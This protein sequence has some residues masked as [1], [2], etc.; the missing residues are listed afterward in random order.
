M[1]K[2]V[3]LVILIICTAAAALFG[4]FAY[5]STKG[6]AVLASRLPL[7]SASDPYVVFE[8]PENE[9]PL[10]IS[11][12][13]TEGQYAVFR[14]GSAGNRILSIAKTAKECAVLIEDGDEE[15][16]DIYAVMR[17]LP[18]DIS[19][20]SKGDLPRSWKMILGNT[21]VRKSGENGS[22]EIKTTDADTSLYYS[23]EREIA[24]ISHNRDSFFKMLDVRSGSVKGIPKNYWGKEKKS[25]PA[26]IEISDGGLLFTDDEIQPPL[27]LKAAWRSH[28]PDKKTGRIGEAIWKIQ[29]LDKRISPI[30]LKALE[31]KKWDTTNC[32]IPEP[33]LLSAGMNLPERKGSPSDWPFPLKTI[34]ELGKSMGLSEKKIQKILSG[35]TIFSVGGYNKLL[36]FSLP[37]ILAEFTGDKDLMREL[38]DAFWN[39]LFFGAEPRPIDGFDFGGTT[40]VPF[41]VVGAGR[42]NV[43]ILGLL[44]PESIKETVKLESFIKN[45]EEAIGWIVADLPKIGAALSDMTKMNSFMNDSGVDDEQYFEEDTDNIFQPDNTFSPFDQ[46]IS[47]SFGNVLKG[48]GKTLIVWETA[49]SGRINWYRNSK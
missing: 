39:K 14:E 18:E 40:N 26:H 3:K 15:I 30:F 25:W 47:D 35:E 45:N 27:I 22:W 43:A 21:E 2:R 17:L 23:T 16:F 6:P 10:S 7:P 28:E 44:S 12:L 41:S 4:L 38:V 19:S 46:G 8:T 48:M 9:Y 13:L 29:G 32:I 33:F 37:G 42:G 11:A 5:F 1:S 34:G 31:S 36:W 24:I 20:L 49:E